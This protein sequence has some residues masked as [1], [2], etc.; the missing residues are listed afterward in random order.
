VIYIETKIWVL[1][2]QDK[3]GYVV[4]LDFLDGVPYPLVFTKKCW[5]CRNKKGLAER[6][7]GVKLRQSV[8][9]AGW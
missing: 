3:V 4:S 9:V 2:F 7:E 8:R 6:A 5:G 1:I